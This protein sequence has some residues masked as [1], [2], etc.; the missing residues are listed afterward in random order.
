VTYFL[1]LITI[2]DPQTGDGDMRQKW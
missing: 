2:P 1:I